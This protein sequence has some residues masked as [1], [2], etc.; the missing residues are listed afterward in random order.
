MIVH[1]YVVPISSDSWESSTGQTEGKVY[2]RD[3]VGAVQEYISCFFANCT[4][5]S[6]TWNPGCCWWCLKNH[7]LICA[8]CL[9]LFP[10]LPRFSSSVCIIHGSGRARKTL[11]R[12]RVLYWTQNKEPTQ[13]RPGNEAT[14]CHLHFVLCKLWKG[15][16]VVLYPGLLILRLVSYPDPPST[17]QEERGVWWIVQYFGGKVWPGY[18]TTLRF[19]VCSTNCGG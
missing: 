18:E 1:T 7:F 10:G 8:L 2:E 5:D 17:L 19:V 3:Q 11:F 12:F 13:G 14:L 9:A 15:C 4:R 6:M 16:V